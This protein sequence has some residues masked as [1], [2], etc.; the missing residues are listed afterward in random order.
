MSARIL[1]VEDNTLN[2]QLV[3][4]VLEYRGHEVLEAASVQEGR[5]RLRDGAPDLVLMD[6]QIPGGGGELLLKEIRMDPALSSLFVVAL[7]A[8]AME[9]DR[10]RILERGFDAYVSKPIDVRTFGAQIESYLNRKGV[11]DVR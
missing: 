8:F 2:R 4:D 10:E 1:V 9:G 6:L 7:T 3:R 5:T 11:Q